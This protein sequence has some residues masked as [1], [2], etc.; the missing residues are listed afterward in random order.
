MY[1][2]RSAAW[3][4]PLALF[5][6]VLAGCATLQQIAALRQVDF[7]LDRVA[8]VRLAD[9]D[10]DRVRSYSDLTLTDIGRLSLA[11][12]Q[13]RLPLEFNLFVEG[14]NPP[15]NDVDARLVRFDWTL[16]LEDRE[17]V[18]GVFDQEVVFLPG[19]PTTF[20]LRIELDLL[21][22]F[23][24]NARDLAELALSLSGEG[25]E[26][27]NVALEAVPTI[28]TAIGPIRYPG[29]ITVLSG[30]VGGAP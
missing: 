28:N 15:D 27:K 19:Q 23:K 13:D 12:S 1:R 5:A 18:R 4:A 6:L 26:P 10:L 22:F 24:G 17:T 29:T 30:E 2:A 11:L 3:A 16:L 9:V 7:V 25:G 8:Q 20:P 21:E 14:E